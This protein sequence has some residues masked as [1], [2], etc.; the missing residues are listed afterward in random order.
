MK[1]VAFV[2]AVAGKPRSPHLLEILE[3]TRWISH[4]EVFPAIVPE[5]IDPYKM[6][7]QQ[8]LSSRLM[9]RHISE[10]EICIMLS[11][12]E[13]YKK[14]YEMSADLIYVFED[15][16]VIQNENLPELFLVKMT[17]RSPRIFLFF[18]PNWSIW[19]RGWRNW[20]AVITPPY[21]ACY[22]MN[23]RAI[24]AASHDLPI[25]LADWP[26]WTKLSYFRYKEV[27]CV[28]IFE[29]AHS[30]AEKSRQLS[31]LGKRYRSLKATTTK[32]P[33]LKMLRF[34]MYDPWIWKIF[35]FRSAFKTRKKPRAMFICKF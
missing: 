33:F 5:K 10:I 19:L 8:D 15:D 17:E 16:V 27:H 18:S 9:G 2:I 7:V 28:S 3:N 26:M 12:H 1:I 23:R 31:K 29:G 6:K 4:L 30:Y 21:A 20:I 14:A 24:E 35:N 22:A 34:R 13:V 32:I 25:G 11:H